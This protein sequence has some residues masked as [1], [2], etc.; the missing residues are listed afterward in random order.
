ML[1]TM[2]DFAHRLTQSNQFEYFIVTLIL[3]NA[4]LLG[5]ET[6]PQVMDHYDRWTALGRQATLGVFIV[7]AALKMFAQWPRPDRYFRDGWNIFDFSIIV[8]SLLPATGGF[9]IIARMARLLRLLRLVSAVQELRLIVATLV[10][11][12]PSMLHIVVLM[13]LMVYVYAIIGFQLFHEHDPEHWRNLGI[14]LLS[15]FRI[16]TLEDWTD[17]MYKAMEYH[18][19]TWMY[20]VSFVV[21]GT[22][23]VINLFIAVV[24]NNLDE[25]KQE[26]LRQLEQTPTTDSLLSEL[27]VTQQSLRR[28]EEQLQRRNE[29]DDGSK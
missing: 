29:D 21:F 27:R 10:R 18:P 5:V 8:L 15:L 25:A 1:D 16:V 28:L 20:F 19:L 6:L 24:I 4:V 22:F 26:R 12:I 2:R 14:S 7:E 13:S 11:S 23:V 3:S 17:I 9:A